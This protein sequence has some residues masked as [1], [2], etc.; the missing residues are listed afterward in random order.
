MVKWGKVKLLTLLKLT[1]GDKRKFVHLR[2]E[3]KYLLR[4]IPYDQRKKNVV[5]PLPK[6]NLAPVKIENY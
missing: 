6:L 3:E 4:K 5:N 2:Y 1:K